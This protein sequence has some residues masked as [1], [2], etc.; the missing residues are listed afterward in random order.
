MTRL[1]WSLLTLAL[2]GLIIC[3]YGIYLSGRDFPAKFPG[4]CT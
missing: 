3:G 4:C 2:T 1:Y